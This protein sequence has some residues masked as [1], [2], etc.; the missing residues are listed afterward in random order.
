MSFLLAC[1]GFLLMALSQKRPRALLVKGDPI[2]KLQAVV[3]R[4]SSS[5]FL[6]ASFFLSV[7]YDGLSLGIIFWGTMISISGIFVSILITAVGAYRKNSA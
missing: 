1:I 4:I 7:A 5:L 3:Y 6:G 2:T